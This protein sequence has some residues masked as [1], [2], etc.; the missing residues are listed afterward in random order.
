MEWL[1]VVLS[2]ALCIA[3]Q[4]FDTWTTAE[5]LAGGGTE[6]NPVVKWSIHTFGAIWGVKV[7]LLVPA[8]VLFLFNIEAGIAVML[9]FALAGLV[10]GW[11]N[12]R[13]WTP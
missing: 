10:A 13:H 6:Y 2:V 8:A 1:V 9:I 12:I 3:A 7:L 11:L 5:N 4:A